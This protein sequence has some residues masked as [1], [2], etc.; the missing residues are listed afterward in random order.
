[1]DVTYC[2]SLSEQEINIRFNRY[3]YRNEQ[4]FVKDF[5]HYLLKPFDS[6]FRLKLAVYICEQ[7]KPSKTNEQYY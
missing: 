6:S 5:Y 1:M 3:A 7:I 4:D 2:T